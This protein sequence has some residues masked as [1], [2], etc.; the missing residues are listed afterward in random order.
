[1]Q[2][3]IEGYRKNY[4]RL[5]PRFENL[6]D[7]LV[8]LP[9]LEPDRVRLDPSRARSEGIEVLLKVAPIDGWSG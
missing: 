2:L 8:L 4:R 9:E 7:P 3:R 5:S 1:V 6:F